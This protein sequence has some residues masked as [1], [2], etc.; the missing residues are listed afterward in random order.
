MRHLRPIFFAAFLFSVHLAL[1]T[2]LNSTMLEQFGDATLTSVIYTLAAALSFLLL[3]GV[4]HMIRVLGLARTAFITLLA[5]AAFLA[6]I[7]IG[8]GGYL[9]MGYFIA[10]FALNAVVVYLFDLF[11]EH[12][13]STNSVGRTRGL[14]LMIQNLGWVIA[15]FASGLL[16]TTYSIQMVYTIAA[17]LVVGVLYII[18]TSQRDF[19]D[20]EYT[21][22]SIRTAFLML[23]DRPEL[24][25]A[26][27]INLILQ[28]F[29]AWMVVYSPI[30]L[31]NLGFDWKTIGLILSIMLI[32]FVIFQYP[33]GRLTD[34]IGE[35]RLIRAGFV[36]AGIATVVFGLLHEQSWWVYAAIL[37][38]TRTGASIIEVATDSFFFRHITDGDAQVVGLYRTM[39]P[40][41][42][43]IG[44]IA[45]AGVL[46]FASMKALFVILGVLC[47][48]MVWYV[49]RLKTN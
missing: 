3:V 48:G 42:Y 9:G 18:G 13:S 34:R 30:Y 19:V 44:P 14:Y 31:S 2:Y 47:I 24:R 43:I 11:V 38:A 7:S 21:H 23:R 8:G 15:P 37:F 49:K 22:T 10:Y 5:S 41:A 16:I 12:Y 39:L 36:I 28:L 6:M 29:Y 33:A 4:P 26:M 46:V 45:G 20:R 27:S 40:M 35:P 25:R 17:I 1:L 32:P